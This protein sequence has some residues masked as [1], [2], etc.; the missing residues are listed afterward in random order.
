MTRH[1]K[2]EISFS[3][4]KSVSAESS[5]AS[6]LKY[7]NHPEQCYGINRAAHESPASAAVGNFRLTI[8]LREANVKGMGMQKA[9]VTVILETEDDLVV[10][11][12]VKRMG[13]ERKR[14]ESQVTVGD[15]P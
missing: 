11:A 8:N 5:T 10:E 4:P 1:K 13:P 14:K 9:K 15:E 7:L 6:S 3:G 2:G 12:N